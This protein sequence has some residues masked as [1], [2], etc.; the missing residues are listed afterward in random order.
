MLRIMSLPISI[1]K[2]LMGGN[3]DFSLEEKVIGTWIDGKPLYSKGFIINGNLSAGMTI[4]IENCNE[5]IS[6]FGTV[7]YSTSNQQCLFP[8]GVAGNYCEFYLINDK[9]QFNCSANWHDAKFV[10]LYT[11]KDD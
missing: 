6:S 2:K 9:I 1:M 3:M 11:K 4:D 5:I 7:L 10:V 8:Y